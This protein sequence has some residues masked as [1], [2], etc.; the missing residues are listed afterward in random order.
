MTGRAALKK[1]MASAEA[2]SA[3]RARTARAASMNAATQ[4]RTTLRR[5]V[6]TRR[7]MAR[8]KTIVV[9]ET[10]CSATEATCAGS[11]ASGGMT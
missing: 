1:K 8:P 5:G 9:C 10:A 4:A 3:R 2:A 6:G 7:S 11:V